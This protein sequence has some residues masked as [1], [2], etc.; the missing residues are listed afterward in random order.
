[1]GGLISR[2]FRRKTTEDESRPKSKKGRRFGSFRRPRSDEPQTSIHQS[3]CNT[4]PSRTAINQIESSQTI[5]REERIRETML[6]VQDTVGT[7]SQLSDVTGETAQVPHT[8]KQENDQNIAQ[9]YLDVTKRTEENMTA[10]RCAAVKVVSLSSEAPSQNNYHPPT[11]N[12]Q[13]MWTTEQEDMVKG[14]KEVYDETAFVIPDKAEI[15][16]LTSEIQNDSPDSDTKHRSTTDDSDL[17]HVEYHANIEANSVIF[18]A[19]SI[20]TVP[21]DLREKTPFGIQTEQTTREDD[22]NHADISQRS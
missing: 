6:E 15:A 4:L 17:V 13:T 18:D 21:S 20:P 22:T 12:M 8:D 14:Q 16:Q 3:R 19:S 10:E 5:E 1:M 9:S 11:D 2:I 7:S